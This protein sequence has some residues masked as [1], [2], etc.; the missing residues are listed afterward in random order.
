MDIP[1]NDTYGDGTPI[2]KNVDMW[3]YIAFVIGWMYLFAWSFSF[4]P[5]AIENY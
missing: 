1:M 5:Q 3:K 2:V 4:F